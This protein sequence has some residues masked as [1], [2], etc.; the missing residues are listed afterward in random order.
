MADGYTSAEELI[1]DIRDKTYQQG[2]YK[3]PLL[4]PISGE[5]YEYGQGPFAASDAYI[6]DFWDEISSAVNDLQNRDVEDIASFF[7]DDATLKA[8]LVMVRERVFLSI[9]AGVSVQWKFYVVYTRDYFIPIS[10]LGGTGEHIYQPKHAQRRIGLFCTSTFYIQDFPI[11]L[12][13]SV[14]V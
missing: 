6:H 10:G 14:L 1:D 12:F 11:V 2:P 3:L 8:K 5:F 13:D 9:I 7:N 4:F